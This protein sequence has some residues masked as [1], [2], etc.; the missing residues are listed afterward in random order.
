MITV[1]DGRTRGGEINLDAMNQREEHTSITLTQSG[2]T[3]LDM[4]VNAY[5]RHMR[6]KRAIM[7]VEQAGIRLNSLTQHTY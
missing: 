7:A 3:G 1:T 2:R 5:T 6:T 4:D